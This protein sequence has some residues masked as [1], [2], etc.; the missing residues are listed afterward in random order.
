MTVQNPRLEEVT[1]LL[2]VETIFGGHTFL[3]NTQ[4]RWVSKTSSCSCKNA[5][6]TYFINAYADGSPLPDGIA[7]MVLN[8][9]QVVE[10]NFRT[11]IPV[12]PDMSFEEHTKLF[13]TSSTAGVYGIPPKETLKKYRTKEGYLKTNP[14]QF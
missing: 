12:K 6:W 1:L 14:N 2:S 13:L 7:T 10:T 9:K 3:P 11:D 4:F 5:T 8:S